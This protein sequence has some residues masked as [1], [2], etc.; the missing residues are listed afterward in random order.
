MHRLISSYDLDRPKDRVDSVIR[1]FHV[2]PLFP[3]L[4][5]ARHY[6][7]IGSLLLKLF[8]LNCLEG[9]ITLPRAVLGQG[10]R[11]IIRKEAGMLSRNWTCFRARSALGPKCQSRNRRGP[12]LMKRVWLEDGRMPML[13]SGLSGACRLN[14]E[15]TVVEMVAS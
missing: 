2:R 12:S 9:I 10:N 4:H 13:C 6:P 5:R 1:A 3:L 7:L 8:R 11:N 15:G 14:C